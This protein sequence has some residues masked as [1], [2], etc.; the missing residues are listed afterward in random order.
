MQLNSAKPFRENSFV[1]GRVTLVGCFVQFNCYFKK[2][3]FLITWGSLFQIVVLNPLKLMTTEVVGFILSTLCANLIL[4]TRRCRRPG[5]T[6]ITALRNH[7]NTSDAEKLIWDFPQT[8][9]TFLI[10]FHD[11][12]KCVSGTHNAARRSAKQQNN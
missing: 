2:S 6:K 12:T 1:S 5:L 11:E 8:K 10:L 4:F 9:G 3:R 7:I